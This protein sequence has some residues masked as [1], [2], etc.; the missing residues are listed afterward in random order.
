MI[1]I[2][3]SLYLINHY[4]IWSFTNEVACKVDQQL[5][6]ASSSLLLSGPRPPRNK[7]WGVNTGQPSTCC[8]VVVVVVVVYFVVINFSVITFMP[9]WRNEKKLLKKKRI[10]SGLLSTDVVVLSLSLPLY[11]KPLP[12]SLL[13]PQMPLYWHQLWSAVSIAAMRSKESIL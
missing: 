9:P 11:N 7:S 13:T 3:L 4:I 5:A 1:I 6:S 10:F 2:F 12:L 8:F